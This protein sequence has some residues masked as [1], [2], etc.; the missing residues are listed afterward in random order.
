MPGVNE[1]KSQTGENPHL[2]GLIKR[3]PHYQ[4]V[5]PTLQDLI[6]MNLLTTTPLPILTGVSR[7]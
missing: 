4:L 5:S 1:I 6:V 2:D 3:I 7:N